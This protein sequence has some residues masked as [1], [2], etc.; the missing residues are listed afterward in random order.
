MDAQTAVE[1]RV[2]I[3]RVS[4]LEGKCN[5]EPDIHLKPCPFCG[6]GA[7]FTLSTRTYSDDSFTCPTRTYLGD[8]ICVECKS[9]FCS[10]RMLPVNE[11]G[12]VRVIRDWNSRP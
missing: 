11:D 10:T 8:M 1:L 6:K 12:Q 2:L 7:R 3:A 5:I 4:A 9:C